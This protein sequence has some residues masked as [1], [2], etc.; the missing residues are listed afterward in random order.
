MPA[1]KAAP[2]EPSHTSVVLKALIAADDY[3]NLST[4]SRLTKL[5]KDILRPTIK[6]LRKYNAVDSVES[7][8]QLYWYATPA[9]DTRSWTQEEHRKEDEPRKNWQGGR[10]A[11]KNRLT[12]HKVF[13]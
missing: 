10:K 8:G 5:K 12:V 4:L 13:T 1:S 11:Y 2:V 9:L 7:D 3:V 6:H